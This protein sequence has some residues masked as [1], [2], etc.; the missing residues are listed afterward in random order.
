M[1]AERL[2]PSIKNWNTLLYGHPHVSAINVGHKKDNNTLQTHIS[3][4]RRL[5]VPCCDPNSFIEICVAVCLPES[6]Q[7]DDTFD[8]CHP[9]GQQVPFEI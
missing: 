3:R 2:S 9:Q 8:L 4:I 1:E 5:L 6:G 7:A